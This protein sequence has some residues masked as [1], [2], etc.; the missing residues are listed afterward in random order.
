MFRS[1][2]PKTKRDSLSRRSEYDNLSYQTFTQTFEGIDSSQELLGSINEENKSIDQSEDNSSIDHISD[3][4][5]AKKE[6]SI[7]RV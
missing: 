1:S 4:E 7:A 6:T 3:D 2:L 5:L